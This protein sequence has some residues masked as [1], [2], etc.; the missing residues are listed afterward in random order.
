MHKCSEQG[1][2]VAFVVF[3]RVGIK[4]LPNQNR[5]QVI[6]AGDDEGDDAEAARIEKLKADQEAAKAAEGLSAEAGEAEA[7]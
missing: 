1:L 4:F 3:Q 5:T 7:E 6:K 2:P